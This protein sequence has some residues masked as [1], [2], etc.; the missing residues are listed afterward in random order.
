MPTEQPIRETCILDHTG[1][2]GVKLEHLKQTTTPEPD[3]TQVGICQAF[4]FRCICLKADEN[5]RESW[6]HAHE[7][8]TAETVSVSL[9]QGGTNPVLN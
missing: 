2:L 6:C 5:A 1:D 9:D 4:K 3:Y 7:I 8:M